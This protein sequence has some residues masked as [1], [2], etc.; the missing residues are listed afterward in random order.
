MDSGKPQPPC[1]ITF[2]F[3][4]KLEQ[5][6]DKDMIQLESVVLVKISEVHFSLQFLYSSLYQLQFTVGF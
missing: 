2:A 6:T 3:N 1:V 4:T 5:R